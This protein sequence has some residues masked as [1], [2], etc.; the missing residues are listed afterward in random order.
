MKKEELK[1]KLNVLY[2][3][4]EEKKKTA[5]G[6]FC[7][8]NNPYNIGDIF[9]DHIG[10]IRIE[11]IKYSGYGDDPCCVYE[12]PNLKKDGSERKDKSRR[13]AWQSNDIIKPITP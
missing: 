3:E 4:Y 10:K 12:G 5:M 8:A 2:K 1:S 6:E 13:N 11:N 7:E 9:E